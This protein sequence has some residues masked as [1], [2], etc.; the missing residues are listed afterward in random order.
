MKKFVVL[1]LILLFFGATAAFAQMETTSSA[2]VLGL[3]VGYGLPM[4]DFGDAY[5]GGLTAGASVGYMFT[6]KYGLE[7]GMEWSKF[8]ANDDLVAVLEALSGEDVEANFQFMPVMVDFVANFPMSSSVTPYLK[9]GLGMYF[10][11][12]EITIAD[13]TESDSESD[14]GFNIGG[15]VKFPIS[16]TALIDFGARFHNVMTEDNSTQYFTI[17]AGVDFM[18]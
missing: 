18:F 5:D 14:F 11:T 4:G 1:P 10:E 13:D 16:A 15:G 17:G 6:G 3:N 7:V 9:G 8:A 12:A 2:W